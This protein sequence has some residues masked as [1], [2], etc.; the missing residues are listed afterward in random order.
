ML[1]VPRDSVRVKLTL[2]IL[3][4]VVLSWV[5]SSGIANYFAFL[6][7]RAF[8]QEIVRQRGADA[9]PIPEPRFGVVDFFLGR[10]PI[11][12]EFR[13]PPRPPGPPGPPG[14]PPIPQTP[15]RPPFSETA[16]AAV[17]IL[18]AL[19]LAAVAG[20]WLGRKFT[21][22]LARLARGADAYQSGDFGYSI[23]VEGKDEFAAVATA[24]NEM[25]AR[26]SDQIRRL[27]EDAER[28]RRFMADIA[29]ELRSPVATMATMAGAMRDGLATQPERRDFAVKA[30][31]DTSERLQRLVADVMELARLDL[32]ELPLSKSRT[33]LRELIR[34]AFESHSTDAERAEIVLSTLEDGPPIDALVDP[35]RIAQVLDNVLDNAISYAGKGAHVTVSVTTDKHISIVIADTGRGIAE[36]DA[37]RVVEP[38]Y[39]VDTARTP[40]DCH[41]GLGL[42]IAAKLVEAH[43]GRLTISSRQGRGTTVEIRLPRAAPEP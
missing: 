38:F 30:L 39:R 23:P 3:L 10:P 26:V 25:A 34:S 17:R 11:P 24:M 13:E 9:R 14:P 7:F 4:T 8:R 19:G 22:P 40:D 1:F 27:E 37:A 31:A 33:N 35:D 16:G 15:D 21:R 2:A 18:V 43:D 28:R 32:A 12:R 6:S 36:A 5:I 41:S 29:H 20:S 42:S